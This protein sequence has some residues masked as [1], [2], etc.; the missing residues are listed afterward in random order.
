MY[1]IMKLW[2]KIIYIHPIIHHIKIQKKGQNKTIILII[3]IKNKKK[4]II[5]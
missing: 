3:K 5:F 1:F 4:K 2:T